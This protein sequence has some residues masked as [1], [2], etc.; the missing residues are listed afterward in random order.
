[1]RPARLYPFLLS[2]VPVL[3]IVADNPG[4][5]GVADLLLVLAAT[6]GVASAVYL[7]ARLALGR[8]HGPR[9]APLVALIAMAWFLGYRTVAES[10]GLDRPHLLLAPLLGAASVGLLLWGRRRPDSLDRAGSFLT[11]TGLLLAAFAVTDISRDRMRSAAMLRESEVVRRLSRP[12]AAPAEPPGPRRDIYVIVLDEYAN[13]RVLRER[14]GYDNR[15]FEDSLRALGFH[16]PRLVRSNYVHTMLSIPSLLN[17]AHLAPLADEVGR[18]STDPTLANRLLDRSRVA[19]FL[20]ERGY[21]YVFFPSRWWYS[22]RRSP[23]AD[24]EPQVWDETRPLRELGKT[25]LR[26]LVLKASLV[27]GRLLR[28]MVWDA[29]HVRRSLAG[30]TLAHR[31]GDPVFVVAHVISPHAPY[32]VDGDCRSPPRR[33][34]YVGQ[35]EC[36]NGRVL[37][38]VT[39]LIERSEVPPIILLQGDHGTATLGYSDWPTAA[40]VPAAAARERFGAFGA[41]YL[42]DGGAAEFGDTVTVVNVMGNVLRHYFDAA[43]PREPDVQYL[44]LERAPFDFRQVD[45]GWLAPRPGVIVREA[46][47]GGRGA[48]LSP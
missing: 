12:I 15:A 27:P 7:A 31:F 8:E 46:G 19:G 48:R 43:L 29:D 39:E 5:S 16:I 24:V 4:E 26:R 18:R 30:V 10:S 20:K 28:T 11:L 44:S 22:T 40:E 25:E 37:Q 2:A 14:F 32:A 42:P 6:V 1:M 33:F 23:L 13:S 45:A 3:H 35:L 41:Y 9:L 21:R 38:V 47:E 34:T 36:I 17:A